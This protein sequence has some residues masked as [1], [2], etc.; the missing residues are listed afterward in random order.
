MGNETNITCDEVE[1]SPEEIVY[2]K[3]CAWWIENG[4]SLPVAI[5]GVFL[6]FISLLVLARPSMRSNFFNRLLFILD[7]CDITYLSCEIFEVFRSRYQ[8]FALQHT[9]VNFIYPVRSVASG[10]SIIMT[11]VLSHERY[12][13]I[14]NPAQYRLR[15]SM[16]MTR[17]LCYYTIPLLFIG[18]L[19]YMPKFLDINVDEV[20]KCMN[21][22]NATYIPIRN[23]VTPDASQYDNCT[24]TYDIIPTKL[25]LNYHYILWY[26]NVSN[27]LLTA[28][29][30]VSAL[31][32][33]NWK[34]YISLN[35]FR[36]RQPSH[37]SDSGSSEDRK[38]Q[39]ND[40]K[41]TLILFSIVF[42]FV[43]CHAL[44]I[45]LNI[46]E[47]LSLPK[48][49]E[50]HEKEC[51]DPR[52]V[53]SSIGVPINQLLI[54]IGSSSNFLIYSFFDPAFQQA[55]RQVLTIQSVVQR[56]AEIN[57][58]HDIELHNVNAADELN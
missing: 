7:L 11:I 42:V 17:R 26:I 3:N 33:L 35:T 13:A 51:N 57:A 23:E 16:N 12:Q 49:E 53:W 24:T 46:N 9:F 2:S 37:Q 50:I 45:G 19:Y 40:F 29:M 36:E 18:M 52:T 34:I 25:R 8:T 58:S 41:K 55:L 47:F 54:I 21:G 6:N 5:L 4:G 10:L 20:M 30:P 32:Y 38:N 28:I 56:A 15:G 31:A 27:L 1:L 39:T 48:V 43:F 14:T 44:R 22:T